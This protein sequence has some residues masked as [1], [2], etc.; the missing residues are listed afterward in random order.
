[1]KHRIHLILV[2]GITE[3][4]A[5]HRMVGDWEFWPNYSL[6]GLAQNLPSH[7][8]QAPYSGYDE[9][10]FA[11]PPILFHNEQPSDRIAKLLQP[12]AMPE[13]AFSIEF[14]VSYHTNLPIGALATL[15][16]SR[17]QAE[18]AWSFGFYDD[19]FSFAVCCGDTTARLKAEMK[20]K[21]GFKK[22]WT[23]WV[24]TYDGAAVKL[25]KNGELVD[26][27][28]A[29]RVKALNDPDFEIAAYTKNEPFMKLAH[30]VR[31]VRLH[32]YALSKQDIRN[33]FDDLCR[34]VQDGRLYSDLF[35][36]TAGPYLSY[37]Q[38]DRMHLLWETSNPSY[39]TVDYGKTDKLEQHRIVRDL[40]RKHEVTL[41]GLDPATRY[42]YR[43]TSV[44]EK[45]DTLTS[46]RLSFF[47]AVDAQTAFSFAV[48]GDTEA[49]THVN[50]KIANA[51]WE[52]RPNFAVLTGDL[53]DGGTE[54][55]RFEWTHEFF[56]GL[57]PL[58]GRIPLVTV[59]GNGEGD[60]YWYSYY[61]FMPEP[62][63]YYRFSYGNADFFMLNSNKTKSEFAPD[64]KQY[65]WLEGELAKSKATW[66]FVVHHHPPYTSEEDDYGNTWTNS[67]TLYG[68]QEIYPVIP[69]Y[70][71]YNVDMVLYGHIHSYERSWPIRNNKIDTRHGIIY[72]QTGG[73]GGN[74]ADHSP[75]PTWFNL[76]KER[77]YHY[78][79]VH[80]HHSRLSLSMFD[81][82]GRMKDTFERTK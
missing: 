39:A 24:G 12:S 15:R 72:L 4:F 27:T 65:K 13:K 82:E 77:G 70:E 32:N 17:D 33:R 61:N 56:L 51:V 26:S 54:K 37:P 7:T 14:W 59:P 22:Y 50:E 45:G 80:I 53:T 2:L 25:Y 3:L 81:I 52:K 48:F 5:Q 64:G 40:Q 46:G 31:E 60:L 42:Y 49:R 58:I 62:R 41:T 1:M 47:T 28:A 74:L 66:K 30:F 76:K 57:N 75:T 67:A 18:P 11:S 63:A 34:L 71:K 69:L 73:A 43:V 68:D 20:Y 10:D 38:R 21:K 55:H 35:H 19:V 6:Y 36:Y 16:S 8:R 9:L 79:L 78:V 29:G 44:S 23:H